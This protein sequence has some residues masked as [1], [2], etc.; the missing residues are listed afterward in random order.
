MTPSSSTRI[1]SSSSVGIVVTIGVERYHRKPDFFSK[2]FDGFLIFLQVE[3]ATVWR[4]CGLAVPGW[5]SAVAP[6]AKSAA[7]TRSPVVRFS[8]DILGIRLFDA[9]GDLTLP[10]GPKGRREESDVFTRLGLDGRNRDGV[11][12]VVGGAAARKIVRRLVQ[13]LQNRPDGRRARKSFS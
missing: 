8:Q 1:S 12:D 10:S 9:R 6:T 5:R 2:N 4:A 11:D 13:T 7:I 3:L